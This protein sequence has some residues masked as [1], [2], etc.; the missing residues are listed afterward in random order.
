M[1]YYVGS[2]HI[3]QT[4][5]LFSLAWFTRRGF[6][7]LKRFFL[8]V[9]APTHDKKSVLII[10]SSFC[11]SIHLESCPPHLKYRVITR[12]LTKMKKH[13]SDIATWKRPYK[14]RGWWRFWGC[15][16]NKRKDCGGNPSF[17]YPLLPHSSVS[18]LLDWLHSLQHHNSVLT[19]ESSSFCTQEDFWSSIFFNYLSLI[20]KIVSS[21]HFC[22]TSIWPHTK[23]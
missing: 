10:M 3:F 12:D 11:P 15:F 6:M 14:K 9:R 13:R 20:S 19:S 23:R 7:N 21:T 2:E 5:G 4:L 18:S 8:S 22:S 16:W 1:I 17:I